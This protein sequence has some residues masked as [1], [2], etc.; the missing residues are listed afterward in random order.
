M[1]LKLCAWERLDHGSRSKR[2][3]SYS[4]RENICAHDGSRQQKR[5]LEKM[6]QLILFMLVNKGEEAGKGAHV[7]ARLSKDASACGST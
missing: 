3:G 2:K 6:T 4:G 5:V 7:S 1:I